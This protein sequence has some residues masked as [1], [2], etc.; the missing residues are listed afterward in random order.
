LLHELSLRGKVNSSRLEANLAKSRKLI[1]G[2]SPR[3]FKIRSSARADLEAELGQLAK[4]K[5]PPVS[6]DNVLVADLFKGTRKYLEELALEINGTYQFH[7]FNA[8]AVVCRR[9]VEILLIEAFE[10]AGKASAI[11]RNGEY[12]ML[13][14]II[15]VAKSGAHIKLARGTGPALDEIKDIG[16]TGAHHRSRMV[17]K[18]DID[19]VRTKLRSAVA[20]LMRLAELDGG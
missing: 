1:R 17:H 13:A 15:R 19:G 18:T 7:F 12:V 2:K 10:K 3:T 8:C 9:L 6:Q 16:D 4:P 14:D 20:D 11:Q 5:R